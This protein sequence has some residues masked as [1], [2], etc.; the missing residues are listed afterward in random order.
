MKQPT[1]GRVPFTPGNVNKCI[2]G[3]CPVQQDSQCVKEKTEKLEEL[4]VTPQPERVPGLYCSSGAAA[5]QDLDVDR[6]C[7]C[8]ACD[9]YNG[10]RLG[11]EQPR[12]H[13]CKNGRA[14]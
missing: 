7:I 10:Y 3:Q 1:G 8:G 14:P 4:K 5:C 2:C 6:S 9:V 11:G 12:D 13:F